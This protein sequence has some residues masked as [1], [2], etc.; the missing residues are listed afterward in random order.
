MDSIFLPFDSKKV[1]TSSLIIQRL[2]YTFEYKVTFFQF[3]F[4]NSIYCNWLECLLIVLIFFF[5]LLVIRIIYI[6]FWFGVPCIWIMDEYIRSWWFLMSFRLRDYQFCRRVY[7]FGSFA[8]V[9]MP[10]IIG[11]INTPMVFK[12]FKK[13]TPR[14]LPLNFARI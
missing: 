3:G 14:C 11:R 9:S 8:D 7:A 12:G 10:L 13:E 4:A 2:I 5:C 1:Y 6:R